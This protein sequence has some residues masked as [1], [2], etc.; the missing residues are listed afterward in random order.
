MGETRISREA[1][2]GGMGRTNKF[3]N[4]R[5]QGSIFMLFNDVRFQDLMDF[6]KLT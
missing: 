4:P 3:A 1:L 2:V 5:E 6:E